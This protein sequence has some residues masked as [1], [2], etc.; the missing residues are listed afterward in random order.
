MVK[1]PF[2]STTSGGSKRLR[3]PSILPF[4]NRLGIGTFTLRDIKFSAKPGNFWPAFNSD[5]EQI[6]GHTGLNSILQL[7]QT[8][9]EVSV[10]TLEEAKALRESYPHGVPAGPGSQSEEAKFHLAGSILD[11]SILPGATFWEGLNTVLVKFTPYPSEEEEAA[12]V[13]ISTDMESQDSLLTE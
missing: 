13:E 6:G 11:G 5:G 12:M 9:S 3:V 7:Q 4:L 1:N 10:D 8:A 2:F